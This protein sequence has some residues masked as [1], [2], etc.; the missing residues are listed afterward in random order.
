M[1]NA[2]LIRDPQCTKFSSK[3]TQVLR[4]RH[5][6][7]V[8]A[9]LLNEIV[10]LCQ[11]VL[12]S[13]AGTDGSGSMSSRT[14]RLNLQHFSQKLRLVVN[15]NDRSR[16]CYK[17]R[18]WM[19]VPCHRPSVVLIR[20]QLLACYD[21]VR[22]NNAGLLLDPCEICQWMQTIQ[23]STGTRGIELLGGTQCC[24]ATTVDLGISTSCDNLV[25]S[26]EHFRTWGQAA[27][28]AL[29]HARSPDAQPLDAVPCGMQM[30]MATVKEVL[31]VSALAPQATLWVV[32]AASP[33]GPVV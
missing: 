12:R 8:F 25:L 20:Q 22:K 24:C 32:A 28:A 16:Q 3:I 27:V 17:F 5:R 19:K 1:N 13:A 2:Q 10:Q 9:K 14:T 21:L 7:H 18:L 30:K 31:G 23:R 15:V 6:S 29:P 26:Q 11:C 4:H 33:V